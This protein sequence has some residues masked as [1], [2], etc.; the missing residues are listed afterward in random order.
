MRVSRKHSRFNLVV[1]A[2]YK[3]ICDITGLGSESVEGYEE[4]WKCK[5]EGQMMP[6]RLAAVEHVTSDWV[7]DCKFRMGLIPEKVLEDSWSQ[8]S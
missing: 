6:S 5:V 3:A 4:L 7:L 2:V 1:P 8:Q